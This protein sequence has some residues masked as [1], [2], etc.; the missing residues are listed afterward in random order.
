MEQGVITKENIEKLLH[1]IADTFTVYAPLNREAEK[2]VFGELGADDAVSYDYITTQFSAKSV[3]FPQRE[4]LCTYENGSLKDIVLDE[5]RF[6]VY[7]IRPC[8]AQ[9]LTYL[10]KVFDDVTGRFKDPYYLERRENSIVISLACNEAASTCFCTSVEGS[11]VGSEGSDILAVELGEKL[12]FEAVT[13]KGKRFIEEH[14]DSFE[15]VT[16]E[17]R[18]RREE[19]AKK[20][21]N[22]LQS[23]DFTGLKETL[24]EEFDDEDW[25]R[26]TANCLGCGICTYLCPTC[27]CFDITD[28]TNKLGH[29]IRLRSWDSCQY[30]LFTKHASGHNPRPQKTQRMRQRIM[31]KFSYSVEKNEDIFCVGCGRCITNC[32]VNLDI[33]DILTTFA[34]KH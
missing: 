20:V 25:A 16:E 32:P 10:D 24:D 12:L 9:A 22:E 21:E 8:D 4:V 5:R 26:V 29:G 14:A 30:P 6:L 19:S 7:G 23:Y 15:K 18:S 3:F 13:E 2:P 34:K 11:P 17:D 27:H 33:R 31:H 28:E 1:D